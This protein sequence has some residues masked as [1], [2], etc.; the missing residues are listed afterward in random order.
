MCRGLDGVSG[1]KSSEREAVRNSLRLASFR[2]FGEVEV[3]VEV[4]AGMEMEVDVD[5]DGTEDATGAATGGA[6]AGSTTAAGGRGREPSGSSPGSS[7]SV[8]GASTVGF[9]PD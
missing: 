3:E 5:V 6:G 9:S 1:P 8:V 4:E 7:C 2:F